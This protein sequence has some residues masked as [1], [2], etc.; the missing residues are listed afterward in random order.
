MHP[1]NYPHDNT[2]KYLKKFCNLVSDGNVE[3]NQRKINT[4]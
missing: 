4:D 3:Q 2:G 1:I